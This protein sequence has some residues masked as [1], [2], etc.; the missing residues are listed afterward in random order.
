MIFY[1]TAILLLL[2]LD[3]ERERKTFNPYTSQAF[4]PHNN[5]ATTNRNLLK[6]DVNNFY[7]PIFYKTLKSS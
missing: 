3:R 4:L 5:V 2:T 7:V 6:K 1:L